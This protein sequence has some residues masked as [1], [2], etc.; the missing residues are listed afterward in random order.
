MK[1]GKQVIYANFFCQVFDGMDWEEEFV[2]VSDGGDCYFQ[3]L[4][5]VATGEFS[6]FSVNGEA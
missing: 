6:D 2:F 5:H 1:E 4:Y 3:V